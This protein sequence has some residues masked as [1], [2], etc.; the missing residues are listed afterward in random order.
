MDTISRSAAAAILE[1]M[2]SAGVDELVRCPNC[3]R[4]VVG[5]L[6]DPVFAN[7]NC[8]LCNEWLVT[9]MQRLELERLQREACEREERRGHYGTNMIFPYYDA[10]TKT[11]EVTV[12]PGWVYVG[13]TPWGTYKIGATRQ[14]VQARL[15]YSNAKFVHS[16]YTDYPFVLEAGFH[17][18]FRGKCAGGE[19][20][21]LADEDI[22]EIRAIQTVCGEPVS[23]FGT[24][25]EVKRRRR[26]T[27]W[28]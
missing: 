20:F 2:D 25:A 14:S 13:V 24:L 5:V 18:R 1:Q 8:H 4:W 15:T 17:R 3:G 26:V 10:G 6:L 16:V 27:K 22:D 11:R 7:L 23:H 9:W 19:Y 21:K 28:R 12:N